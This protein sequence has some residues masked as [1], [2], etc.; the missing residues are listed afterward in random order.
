MRSD[1]VVVLAPLLDDDGGLL[2]AV[3]DLT[4]RWTAINASETERS[5]FDAA[6]DGMTMGFTGTF[7]QLD[8]YLAAA[9]GK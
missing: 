6:H 2:Q 8:A 1:R 5:T 9:Q 3:E 7:E 4:V